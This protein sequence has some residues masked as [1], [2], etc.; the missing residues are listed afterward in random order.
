MTD[1]TAPPEV[2]WAP[3]FELPRP[4]FSHHPRPLAGSGVPR[5]GALPSNGFVGA[6]RAVPR[7][8]GGA[9]SVGGVGAATGVSPRNCACGSFANLPRRLHSS[10]GDTPAPSPP[11]PAPV[12]GRNWVWGH[13]VRGA[14]NCALSNDGS[15][16]GNGGPGAARPPAPEGRCSRSAGNSAPSSNEA[17]R[18][19]RTP[20]GSPV[21]AGA[22][23]AARSATY[24][25]RR[26]QS[27]RGG[28]LEAVRAGGKAS[29][30][31]GDAAAPHGQGLKE[32]S[33]RQLTQ[34]SGAS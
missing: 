15:A 28:T 8:P 29:I 11:G 25:R 12:C 10:C 21:A 33:S 7:A 24:A 6:C 26:R 22:R 19:Q 30:L 20:W 16:A 1:V 31:V 27:T 18:R 17:G 9:R 13:P 34:R 4:C 14:G 5:G 2:R 32:C 3:P 23:G